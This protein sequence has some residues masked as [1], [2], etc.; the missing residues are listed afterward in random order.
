MQH[1][2]LNAN[3]VHTIMLYRQQQCM[4]SMTERDE[5]KVLRRLIQAHETELA[6]R[7][8]A[9]TTSAIRECKQHSYGH[10]CVSA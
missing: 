7:V 5:R 6:F 9:Y 2:M 4:P 8:R 10:D 3:D 1:A